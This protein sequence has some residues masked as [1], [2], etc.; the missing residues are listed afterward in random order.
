[1]R[2]VLF[3]NYVISNA[4]VATRHQKH[5]VKHITIVW[6]NN[7]VCQQIILERYRIKNLPNVS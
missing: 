6:M 7:F 3:S 5:S 4:T 2:C 1:M